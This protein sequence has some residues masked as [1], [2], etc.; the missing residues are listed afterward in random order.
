MSSIHTLTAPE[1]FD[2]YIH[3]P[4]ELYNPTIDRFNKDKW[5][6]FEL[7]L[8]SY[9]RYLAIEEAQRK[10]PEEYA[11]A[12][13]VS[14]AIRRV[15][16][17]LSSKQQQLFDANMSYLTPDQLNQIWIDAGR[18]FNDTDDITKY[19][20]LYVN[21]IQPVFYRAP[22]DNDPTFDPR[23]IQY[24]TSTLTNP[25]GYWLPYSNIS[26]N[27]SRIFEGANAEQLRNYLVTLPG[28]NPDDLLSLSRP[29]LVRYYF[30]L[31]LDSYYRIHDR[32]LIQLRQ[33][34][35]AGSLSKPIDDYIMYLTNVDILALLDEFGIEYPVRQPPGNVLARY[36]DDLQM[37]TPHAPERM[38]RK[39][40]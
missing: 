38:M 6:S 15:H 9:I 36:F 39:L 18:K 7:E 33:D 35:E 29:D 32:D 16:L 31:L 22:R 20:P 21:G 2:Y 30:N 12:K 27:I 5:E 11:A 1:L 13:E 37:H 17:P 4:T 26:E 8:K 28:V 23:I 24:L 34:M 10:D 3:H 14:A 19:I 25:I 40:Q